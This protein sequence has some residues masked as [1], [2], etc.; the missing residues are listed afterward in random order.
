MS[1]RKAAR[2]LEEAESD[3]LHGNYDKSASAS[4]FAARMAA[5]LFLRSKNLDIPRRD[6]KL[7]NLLE[8][9]GY[10]LLAGSLRKLYDVRK[11]ADYSGELVT[12][13]E[14]ARSL[15]RA[16]EIVRRLLHTDRRY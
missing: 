4:Y 13:E 7:A 2:L 1:A 8:N 12:R 16:S 3:L 10:A 5:E 14:A 6:D 9:Q 15:D 11:K